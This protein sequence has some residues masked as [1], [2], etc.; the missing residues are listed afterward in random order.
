[1]KDDATNYPGVYIW[2]FVDDLGI[3]CPHYVG[4]SSEK[5]RDRLEAGLVESMAMSYSTTS[6]GAGF[7]Y[8]LFRANVMDNLSKYPCI[9]ERSKNSE[10]FSEASLN[11]VLFYNNKLFMDAV[12]PDGFKNLSDD[13]KD[14]G[15]IVFLEEVMKR[16]RIEGYVK[17]GGANALVC[18]FFLHKKTF[19]PVL[20]ELANVWEKYIVKFDITNPTTTDMRYFSQRLKICYSLNSENTAYINN[21]YY[22]SELYFKYK[23]PDDGYELRDIKSSETGGLFKDGVKQ[24]R[25]DFWKFQKKGYELLERIIKFSI[26][27]NINSLSAVGP[28]KN[29]LEKTKLESTFRISKDTPSEVRSFFVQEQSNDLAYLSILDK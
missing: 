7:K 28:A 13:Y 2:G 19:I 24:S 14:L 10:N 5:I 12:F 15:H 22:P 1:M 3:F 17:N 6:K 4:Q 11:H 23:F 9:N 21:P 27:R 18:A 25:D 20:E 16:L 26:Q 8:P 29:L